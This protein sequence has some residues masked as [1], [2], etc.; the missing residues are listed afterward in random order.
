MMSPSAGVI[1]V[2]PPALSSGIY[3]LK[4]TANN[5]PQ[6]FKLAKN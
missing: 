6:Y 2:T 5:N 3:M 1:A 4:V